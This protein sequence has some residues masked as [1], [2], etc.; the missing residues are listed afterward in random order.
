MCKMKKLEE[1]ITEKLRVTKSSYVPDLLALMD[2]TDKNE[3]ESKY[4]Q[5][6]EYI[7]NDSDLPIAEL[8]Y[9]KNGLKRL[10]R[11]YENGYDTFLMFSEN[12]IFY[13][14]W[15]EAYYMYRPIGK[16]QVRTRSYGSGFSDFSVN[17]TE[18]SESGGIYVITENTELV[19]QVDYLMQK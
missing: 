16:N 18:I 3:Y 2:S 8:E 12:F 14:T 1:F 11:K 4:Q 15:G 13:G 9:W 19:K 6:L 17:E 5:L 10:S 7:K